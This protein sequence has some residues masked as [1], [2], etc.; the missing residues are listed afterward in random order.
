M[1]ITLAG[2]NSD[3]IRERQRAFAGTDVDVVFTENF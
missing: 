3:I 2:I 1:K